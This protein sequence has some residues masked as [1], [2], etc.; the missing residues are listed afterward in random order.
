MTV[1][2]SAKIG[3]GSYLDMSLLASADTPVREDKVALK[4]TEEVL[5]RLGAYAL[6]F[7]RKQL[8]YGVE[9]I[10]KF[11]KLGV[12][13]RLNDKIERLNSLWR[14]GAVPEHESVEDTLYDIIG[15]GVIGLL[16]QNGIWPEG[17]CA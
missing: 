13:V 7:Y 5:E 16:L 10:S 17:G 12:L 11:G 8:D 6:M 9:N 4:L 3:E 15:Y 14:E 1:S 2:A